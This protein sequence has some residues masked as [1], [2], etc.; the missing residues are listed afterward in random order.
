VFKS[1]TLTA[2]LLSS[3]A[4]LAAGQSGGLLG[5]SSLRLFG[6]TADGRLVS[7]KETSPE[8]V[9]SVGSISG[10]AG[11][12]KLV[13]IDFRPATGEL[14]GL[15]DAGGVY[16]IDT[17][18]AVASFNVQI[19]AALSGTSFGVDFNPVVDRLRIVSDSGQNL[20]V[21][22]ATGTTTVDTALLY[23]AA[24]TG[25]SGAAYTNNDADPNTATTLYDI[26]TLLDQVAIQAP[27]NAGSLN[28]TGKLVLDAGSDVG[29]DIHSRIQDGTTV[30]LR[31]FA[32]LS[33]GGVTHLYGVALFSGKLTDRGSFAPENQVVAL[34][35]PIAAL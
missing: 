11:D 28:A 15:G 31:A 5:T 32:T 29:F 7:F 22:V 8:V 19:G 17:G 6:L 24:A 18:T 12:T 26:D 35:I 2:V 3:L 21:D 23:T 1:L 30:E 13:G 14:Y 4:S 10:L 27:P 33:V 34:A 20:R 16:T 25:V 9:H